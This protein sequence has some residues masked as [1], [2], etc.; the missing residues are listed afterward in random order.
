MDHSIRGKN[1]PTWG[2]N[3]NPHRAANFCFGYT[4]A[5]DQQPLSGR[6]SRALVTVS[7]REISH[8]ALLRGQGII[9]ILV[10]LNHPFSAFVSYGTASRD[11]SKDRE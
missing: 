10:E 2:V 3:R 8:A 5:R 1:I 6:S 4:I 11:R 7:L 9:R